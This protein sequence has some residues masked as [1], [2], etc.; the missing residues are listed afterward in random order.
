MKPYLL[1]LANRFAKE[2]RE[3]ISKIVNNVPR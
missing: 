3:P 2:K 1:I